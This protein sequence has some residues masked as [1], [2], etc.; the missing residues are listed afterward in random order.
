MVGELLGGT[1][2]MMVCTQVA[3][4]QCEPCSKG[5][6]SKAAEAGHFACRV[7]G[8]FRMVDAGAE[9]ILKTERFLDEVEEKGVCFREQ[10]VQEC[11]LSCKW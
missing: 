5:G 9:W 8:G 11:D 1:E 3:L 4:T 10:C 7:W 2:C 6:T